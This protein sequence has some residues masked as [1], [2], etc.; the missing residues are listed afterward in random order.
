MANRIAML[1][2]VSAMVLV[3]CARGG[4]DSAQSQTPARPHV[5]SFEFRDDGRKVALV[6]QPDGGLRLCELR[7]G[8][9]LRWDCTNL[10][11]IP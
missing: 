4:S 3:A 8:E 5:I 10:P 2:A 1:L 9:A 7:G 11:A 6:E